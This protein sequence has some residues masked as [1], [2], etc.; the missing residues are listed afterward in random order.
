MAKTD[1][2]KARNNQIYPCYK[3]LTPILANDPILLGI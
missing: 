2:T 3:E 1:E